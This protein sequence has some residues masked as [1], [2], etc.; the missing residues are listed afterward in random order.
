MKT[1]LYMN[2]DVLIKGISDLELIMLRSEVVSNV[3]IKEY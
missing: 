3:C 1:F 2:E